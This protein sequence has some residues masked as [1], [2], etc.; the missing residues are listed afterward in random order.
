MLVA[1]SHEIES[2]VALSLLLKVL[3]IEM[4][5]RRLSIY[6]D[7]EAESVLESLSQV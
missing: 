6:T 1:E 3:G 5:L 7:H 4:V 2:Y